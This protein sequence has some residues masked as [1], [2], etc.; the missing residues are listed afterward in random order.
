MRP[1][2]ARWARAALPGRR[3][4]PVEVVEVGWDHRVLRA[5]VDGRPWIFR[6]PR[7][8]DVLPDVAR[9]R[10]L[11]AL[12]RDR[13]PVP[14]PHWQ[15][16]T[17]V[18]GQAV[19]GYPELPGHPAGDEP[20]SD[21]VFRFRLPVPPPDGYARTLGAALAAL[22]RFPAD[23]VADAIGPP[24]AAGGAGRLRQLLGDVERAVDVPGTLR[25]WWLDA[26]DGRLGGAVPTCLVHGDVHPG[27]TLVDDRGLLTGL[28]DWTDA[29]W[30]DP[31]ADFVDPRHAFGAGFA[32]RLLDR[33]AAA[34]G[35]VDPGLRHRM[36]TLQAFGPLH[37]AA[38][39]LSA[40]SP[41]H[42]RLATVRMAAS[43]ARLADGLPP[44]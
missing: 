5:A 19:L 7:R 23:E 26:L 24:P 12:L 22:H 18:A 10:H 41:H 6:F 4:E 17:T 20:A 33:Y 1:D 32:D 2:L 44:V 34:G 11:L 30:G 42:V 40:G 27:H 13:L 16:D 39:G 37:Q 28:I 43:A 14:V 21:G 8:P 9:E 31:A 15:V 3:V 35:T 25:R 29:G 36:A 38:F